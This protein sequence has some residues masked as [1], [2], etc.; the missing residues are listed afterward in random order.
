MLEDKGVGDLSPCLWTNKSFSRCQSKNC[1]CLLVF[2]DKESLKWT[3]DIEGKGGES[4]IAIATSHLL[5]LPS[6]VSR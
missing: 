3:K 5:T 2:A 4:K 1:V 6:N